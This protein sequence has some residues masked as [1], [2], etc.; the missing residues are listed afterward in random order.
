[1]LKKIH[2]DHP[3]ENT[4]DG[5]KRR[6]RRPK[7]MLGFEGNPR[8]FCFLGFDGYFE[9]RVWKKLWIMKEV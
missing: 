9:V 4:I 5:S 7:I 8:K 1:V 6:W 2:Q 3:Y